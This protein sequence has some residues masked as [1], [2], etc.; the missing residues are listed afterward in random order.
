MSGST[1]GVADRS[2]RA[3]AADVAARAGAVAVAEDGT[4]LRSVGIS[5]LR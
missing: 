4:E 1:S 2:V 5:N 3:G